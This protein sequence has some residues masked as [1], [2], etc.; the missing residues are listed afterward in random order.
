MLKND[1]SIIP[2]LQLYNA[3]DK[4][5]NTITFLDSQGERKAS[6]P[7]H[8]TMDLADGDVVCIITGM[9]LKYGLVSKFALRSPHSSI[10]NSLGAC[11]LLCPA[12]ANQAP[13]SSFC[14]RVRR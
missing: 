14:M 9:E 10:Q 5:N 2:T 11:V 6:L 4:E 7:I 13:L 8:N 12:F 1:P 3:R